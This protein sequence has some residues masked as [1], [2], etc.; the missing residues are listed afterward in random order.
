MIT[1][2]TSAEIKDVLMEPK[3]KVLKEPY[4]II[5]SP[6]TQENLTVLLSGKNGSEFNKT[7]GFIPKYPAALIYK[8]LYGQGVIIIQ[9]N[10]EL[11][12][13]K[14]VRIAGLRPGVEIEVPSGYAHAFANIGKNFLIMVDNAPKED[15]YKDSEEI[16]AH[17]GLAYYIIDK[18]GEIAF[19]KND[20]YPFHPQI[21][22]Y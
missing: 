16:E 1:T 2:I 12:E 9:R 4:S 22:N 13:A 7:I 20:N 5:H 18:K 15:K 17:H 19:E 10:D 11:G 6:Q 3:E 21:S 14:E 8:C